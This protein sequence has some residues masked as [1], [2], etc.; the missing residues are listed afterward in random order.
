MEQLVNLAW[1]FGLGIVLAI[2]GT[3]ILW[4]ILK[5][6]MATTAEREKNYQN[7]ISNHMQHQT[8]ILNKTCETLTNHDKTVQEF[9][10]VDVRAAHKEH[11][12]L[13]KEALESVRK[14]PK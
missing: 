8:E 11:K 14:C 12:E 13:L 9:F 7:I 5:W 2:S 10:V 3:V 1:N 4:N 6:V